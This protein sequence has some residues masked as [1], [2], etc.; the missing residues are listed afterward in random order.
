MAKAG[1]S[2]SRLGEAVRTR[3][4]MSGGA[5]LFAWTP[6]P[7]SIN[8][9]IAA[10]IARVNSPEAVD[11]LRSPSILLLAPL[12]DQRAPPRHQHQYFQAYAQIG[13]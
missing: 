1:R 2:S 4:G 10:A 6:P 5:R 13:I 3:N 8:R 9:D 11:F 7:G 12:D